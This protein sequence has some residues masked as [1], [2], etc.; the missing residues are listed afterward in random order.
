MRHTQAEIT[1][2]TTLHASCTGEQVA[3]LQ[4]VAMTAIN[5]TSHG[6][7]CRSTVEAGEQ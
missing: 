5:G 2:S 6:H 7:V 3:D 1:E 4:Q